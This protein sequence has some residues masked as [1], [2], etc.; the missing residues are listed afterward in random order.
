M[1]RFANPDELTQIIFFCRPQ[2]SRLRI[3]VGMVRRPP[4]PQPCQPLGARGL[5]ETFQRR[6]RRRTVARR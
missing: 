4:P 6:S 1:D 5:H 3:I 2:L